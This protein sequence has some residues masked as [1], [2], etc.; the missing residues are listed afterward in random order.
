MMRGRF[1]PSPFSFGYP[2]LI[3]AVLVLEAVFYIQNSFD[4]V[5]PLRSDSDFQGLVQR[6]LSDVHLLNVLACYKPDKHRR[7]YLPDVP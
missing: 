1:W 3:L 6:F 4:V 2:C 5:V 7:A